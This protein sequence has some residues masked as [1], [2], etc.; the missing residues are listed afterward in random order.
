MV[1]IMVMAATV[2]CL[3]ALKPHIRAPSFYS[4]F[5]DIQNVYLLTYL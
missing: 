4:D 3:P 2:N 5:G 1:M